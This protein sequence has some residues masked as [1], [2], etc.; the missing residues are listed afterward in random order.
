[1][2]W[3]DWVMSCIPEA[4]YD[5]DSTFVDDLDIRGTTVQS[6][7]QL[8]AADCQDWLQNRSDLLNICEV[9]YQD[10]DERNGK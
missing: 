4:E 10:I 1:M 5:I 9:S 3:I 6:I 7:N 2:C 8:M